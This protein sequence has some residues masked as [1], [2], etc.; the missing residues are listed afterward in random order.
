MK[1]PP[2]HPRGKPFDPG[3]CQESVLW[4]D[5]GMHFHQCQRKPQNGSDYCWQHQPERMEARRQALKKRIEQK[6]R[7]AEADNET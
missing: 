2:N 3:R 5:A 1:H 6:I 7:L 4:G